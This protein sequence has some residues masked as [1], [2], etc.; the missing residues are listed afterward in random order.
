ME[1]HIEQFSQATRPFY[2]MP[3]K[4]YILHTVLQSIT[5]K[6]YSVTALDDFLRLPFK[7]QRSASCRLGID[8]ALTPNISCLSYCSP[9]SQ[10]FGQNFLRLLS[11]MTLTRVGLQMREDNITTTDQPPSL[12]QRDCHISIAYTNSKL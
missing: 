7:E 6:Y 8:W 4:V 3:S 1:L 10:F 2:R 9:L 12:L 11:Y 5:T